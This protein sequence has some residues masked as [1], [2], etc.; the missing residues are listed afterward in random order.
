MGCNHERLRTVGNRL[1]CKICGEE[2]PIEYLTGERKQATNTPA[3]VKTDKPTPKKRT[4]K[5]AE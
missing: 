5:K 3:E 2:L 1:F 4:A